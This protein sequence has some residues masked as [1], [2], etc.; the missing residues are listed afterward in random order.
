MRPDER[1]QR[2]ERELAAFPNDVD[3]QHAVIR[4][5]VRIGEFLPIALEYL[6]ENKPVLPWQFNAIS[7]VFL[8]A[9]RLGRNTNYE[10]GR[11]EVI[12]R[13]EALVHGAIASRRV[14]KWGLDQSPDFEVDWTPTH[15]RALERFYVVTSRTNLIDMEIMAG[16]SSDEISALRVPNADS[17]GRRPF[18][19]ELDRRFIPPRHVPALHLIE[20]CRAQYTHGGELTPEH[21]ASIPRFFLDK[22]E[23]RTQYYGSDRYDCR[24]DRMP[25]NKLIRQE[26]SGDYPELHM[27]QRALQAVR[28]NK[29]YADD[30]SFYLDVRMF[31]AARIMR[32]VGRGRRWKNNPWQPSRR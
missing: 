5:R 22:L 17:Y 8:E 13:P 11:V 9:E 10:E 16:L 27:P 3:L 20:G 4:E 12:W 18:S 25:Y 7:Y 29:G 23:G 31:E 24:H 32:R 30:T 28:S 26:Y 21:S 1:L 19:L 14:P 6:F 15:T 2:L